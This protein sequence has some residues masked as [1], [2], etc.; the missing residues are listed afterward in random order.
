M[1]KDEPFD[2]EAIKFGLKEI[3]KKSIENINDLVNRTIENLNKYPNVKVTYAEK[4]EAAVKE[5][6]DASEGINSL[7]LNNSSTA[8]EMI[9]QFVGQKEMKIIDSYTR[10]LRLE[11]EDFLRDDISGFWDLPDPEPALVWHSFVESQRSAIPFIASPLSYEP[12]I[13]MVGANVVS[14]E[15]S[16]YFVQHLRNI[17]KI[18]SQAEKIFVIAGIE[19]LVA[20]NEEALFQ[21]RCCATFGY[22]SVLSEMFDISKVENEKEEDQTEHQDEK[23][24]WY[25]LMEPSEVHVIL[26]DN[27]R[28]NILASEFSELLHCIGCRACTLRCPRAKSSSEG[29]SSAKDLLFSGF[30]HSIEHAAKYGLFNCT[31]CK[32]CESACPVDI[33]LTSYLSTMREKAISQKLMPDTYTKLSSNI[34][35]FGT[36]YGEKG[37]KAERMGGGK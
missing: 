18:L 3:R 8:A 12:F 20:T 21:A 31:L 33:P 15:G 6:L 29:Y 2:L 16:I 19:K 7:A 17:T 22:E 10:D 25:N 36:P 24:I 27:G 37:M 35:E 9:T 13:G 14:S 32:G 5:I 28:K 11:Q 4:S 30:T 1:R 34:K 26:L 23:K